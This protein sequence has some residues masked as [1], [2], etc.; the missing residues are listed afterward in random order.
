MCGDPNPKPQPAPADEHAP[1]PP[2]KVKPPHESGLKKAEESLGNAI[3]EAKF[4]E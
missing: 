4:D 3:G 2:T 1:D